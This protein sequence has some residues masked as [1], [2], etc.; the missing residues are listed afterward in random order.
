[1]AAL[2][3]SKPVV[4]R[5]SQSSF[6]LRKR[7]KY[8]N[9]FQTYITATIRAGGSHTIIAAHLGMLP[10]VLWFMVLWIAGFIYS[11]ATYF[12]DALSTA[13]V[14]AVASRDVILLLC[15]LLFAVALP[16]FGRFLA[17]NEGRFLTDFLIHH[18]QAHDNT[19]NA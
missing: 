8:G 11:K 10:L 13:S 14:S 18:L 19:R 2:F 1:M 6:R 12:A 4:G 16:L 3:G 5:V 17:R 9:I 15:V 7:I